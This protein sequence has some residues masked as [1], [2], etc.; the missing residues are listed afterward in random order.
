MAIEGLVKTFVDGCNAADGKALAHAFA[1]DADFTAI[2]GLKARGRDIIAKSHDEILSTVYR[3]SVNSAKVESIRFPRPD[4]A[5]A[6]VTF[7]F[8]GEQPAG[9]SPS[10]ETWFLS[11]D[12]RT[13]RSSVN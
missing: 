9:R 1:A 10:F 2:T 8:V 5:V 11:P 7:R 6:G 12:R 4:V 13:A 3:G